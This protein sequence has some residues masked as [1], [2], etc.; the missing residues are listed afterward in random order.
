MGFRLA[1]KTNPPLNRKSYKGNPPL[2]GDKGNPPYPPLSGGYKKAMRSH[3]A[4]G[5]L[6]FLTPLSRGGRGGCSFDKGFFQQPRPAR[7]RGRNSPHLP[8]VP[9]RRIGYRAREAG[10]RRPPVDSRDRPPRGEE[11]F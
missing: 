4:E 5:V 7:G 1:L 10:K 8:C 11:A 3:R 6:L 2:T 9:E